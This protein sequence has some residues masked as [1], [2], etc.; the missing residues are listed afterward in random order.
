MPTVRYT[1][2]PVTLANMRENRVRRQYAVSLADYELDFGLL[3]TGGELCLAGARPN[4]GSRIC[5]C[6]A[7]ADI[8]GTIVAWH[9]AEVG[10]VDAF[11]DAT[12]VP[13]FGPRTVCTCCGIVGG[14]RPA[15]LAGAPEGRE[16]D[17][18]NCFWARGFRSDF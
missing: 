10:R 8:R 2:P 3:L 16:P 12:P 11:D 4:L 13:S 14:R 1:G 6:I 7:C 9:V 17:G 15:Q 5:A 18:G